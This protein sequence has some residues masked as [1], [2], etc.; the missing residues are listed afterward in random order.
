MAGPE[1]R[2]R[3]DLGFGPGVSSRMINVTKMKADGDCFYSAVSFALD[4][5]YS[6]HDLRKI[7]ADALTE[8]TLDMMRTCDAAGVEG[9][10]HVRKCANVEQLRA[11]I[12]RDAKTHRG[13]NSKTNIKVLLEES[14]VPVFRHRWLD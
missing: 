13:N 14:S 1:F 6:V 11:I 5:E 4:K 9:Y 3:I 8:E 12:I 2:L 10:S 7:V